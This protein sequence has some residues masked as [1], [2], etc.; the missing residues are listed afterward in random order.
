MC[1]LEGFSRLNNRCRSGGNFSPSASIVAEREPSPR[2]APHNTVSFF[3]GNCGHRMNEAAQTTRPVS[4]FPLRTQ[5]WFRLPAMASTKSASV[6]CA[7]SP[8]WFPSRS[9]RGGR[10][11][12]CETLPGSSCVGYGNVQ[13]AVEGGS[14]EFC[15]SSESSGLWMAC[16]P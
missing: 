2:A 15:P 8:S 1:G 6:R 10:R 12:L 9:Q 5:H 16:P 4:F 7:M 3:V 11:L 13:A 14:C